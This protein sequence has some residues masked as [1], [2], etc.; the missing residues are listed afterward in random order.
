MYQS[1]SNRYTTLHLFLQNCYMEYSPRKHSGQAVLCLNSVEISSTSVHE[2][3]NS[4]VDVIFRHAELL[5]V[6]DRALVPTSDNSKGVDFAADE[7]YKNPCFFRVAKVDDASLQYRKSAARASLDIVNGNLTFETCADSFQTMTEILGEYAECFAST[8]EEDPDSDIQASQYFDVLDEVDSD[9][10]SIQARSSTAIANAPM[11][12]IVDGHYMQSVDVP[13]RNT[14]F[15]GFVAG[16]ATHVQAANE[17]ENIVTPLNNAS[18]SRAHDIHDGRV[19]KIVGKNALEIV[20]G[21]F[22][23]MRP[24][25]ANNNDELYEATDLC[26]KFSVKGV[27]ID[28]KL[29]GGLDWSTSRQSTATDP[30]NQRREY[31]HSEPL[32]FDDAAVEI[33]WD[34]FSESGFR[35]NEMNQLVSNND[36]E[37]DS[38]LGDLKIQVDEYH[39]NITDTTSSKMSPILTSLTR[40]SKPCMEVHVRN[41]S[42]AQETLSKESKTGLVGRTTFT[43]HDIEIIDN[44]E[45]SLW[46]KFLTYQKP[47]TDDA[48]EVRMSST[49]MFKLELQS[50][51]CTGAD[52]KSSI[53]SRLKAELMMLRM[54]IDQDALEFL[55]KF[56]SFHSSS[57]P[58]PTEE[59]PPT[60]PERFFRKYLNQAIELTL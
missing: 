56:F 48:E 59:S 58:T 22:T 12:G 37:D 13:S 33:V 36:A 29:Y 5:V 1:V 8:P 3:N 17:W 55:V 47:A 40:S 30:T 44:I 7:H 38:I 57:S 24:E 21:H 42:I 43:I 45:S 10:F 35:E 18:V 14:D 28:W 34:D 19:K 46:R 53:E 32:S 4:G 15:V 25:F 39:R 26:W 54:Y 51:K 31:T 20:E 60:T 49:P 23:T 9:A 16:F 52:Q 41:F 27:N 2:I 6:N 50:Y 11:P